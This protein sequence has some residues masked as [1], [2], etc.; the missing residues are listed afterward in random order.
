ML[1]FYNIL[2]VSKENIH[3]NG[4]CIIR[5]LFNKDQIKLMRSI[6]GNEKKFYFSDLYF[7]SMILAHKEIQSIFD[8]VKYFGWSTSINNDKFRPHHA[9]NDCKGYMPIGIDTFDRKDQIKLLS[10]S[11][12][13]YSTEL[14]VTWP[15]WRCWIL[16]QDHE[17]YSGGTKILPKSHRYKKKLSEVIRPH[18]WFNPPTREGDMLIF[19]LA[20]CHS[21]YFV[22]VKGLKN[23]GLPPMVDNMLKKL[24]LSAPLFKKI[25]Y[26]F[27]ENRCVIA[28]DFAAGN[29]EQ[30]HWA[31]TYQANRFLNK[32]NVSKRKMFEEV[33]NRQDEFFSKGIDLLEP[34]GLNLVKSLV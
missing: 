32:N 26:P 9:H 18:K 23:I 15:I 6:A 17:N 7:E 11:N 12:M 28:H 13:K 8:N 1:Y 3:K 22:R 5:N 14:N 34:T 27:T 4:F 30:L 33:Y 21:G 31:K 24:F 29:Y 10:R 2:D 25:A 16:L 20:C 19:N